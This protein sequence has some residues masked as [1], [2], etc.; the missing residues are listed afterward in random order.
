MEVLGECSV[1]L[2]ACCP[3]TI[4]WDASKPYG[5]PR[6]LCDASLI[7]SLGWTPEIDLDH[8][9]DMVIADYR[10][11]VFNKTARL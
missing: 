4:D 1:D 11:E 5:T 10:A 9:L 7:H 3:A 2:S 6:K 8:G